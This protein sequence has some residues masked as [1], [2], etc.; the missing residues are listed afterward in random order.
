VQVIKEFDG[1]HPTEIMSIE[2]DFELVGHSNH[3]VELEVEIDNF[4]VHVHVKLLRGRVG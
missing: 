4:M 2:A 3:A 1:I